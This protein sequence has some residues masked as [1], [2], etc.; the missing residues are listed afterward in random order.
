MSKK[1]NSY[2][3]IDFETGGLPDWQKG[4]KNPACEIALLGLNGVT[5]EEILRYDNVIKP[6]DQKLISEPGA[7]KV[8]G[9]TPEVCQRDGIQLSQV[10]E[11]FCLVAQETNVY[12]SNIARPIL[13]G[14]NVTYDVPFLEEL[15]QRAEINLA[16]YVSGYYNVHGKFVCHYVDTMV[17]CKQADGHRDEKTVKFSLTEC[18]NRHATDLVDGHRALNDVIATSSLFRSLVAKLRSAGGMTTASDGGGS[19]RKRF[20]I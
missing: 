2:L 5:L 3:I 4:N 10:M 18:C 1:I 15:A 17:M 7:M 16:D 11:D 8:H 6:Y 13:V 14:H 12:Q 20:Q 9:L 19:V